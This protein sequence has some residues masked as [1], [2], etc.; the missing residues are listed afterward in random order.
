[1]Q[2]TIERMVWESRNRAE[3]RIFKFLNNSLTEWQKEKLD[4]LIDLFEEKDKT[5]LAWLRE[6]PGQSSPEAFLKIIKKLEYLRELKLSININAIHPTRLIQLSRMGARY[7]PYSL[8]RFKEDKRYAIL[9]AYL[10][11]LSQDLIDLAI[12]IHDR[13]IM[14]LQSKGRKLKKKCKSKMVNQ[15]MK[16]LFILPTLDQPSLKPKRKELR[17]L[18]CH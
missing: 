13:Q 8:R 3:K 14:I 2:R 12:E 5:P 6:M 11:N 16:K 17:P 10:L 15:L 9:V 18:Y 7:E 4:S 1:M